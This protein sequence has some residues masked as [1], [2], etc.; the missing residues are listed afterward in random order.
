M[1][2]KIKA[3]EVVMS[4][5][6]RASW[7]L[8]LGSFILFL[9]LGGCAPKSPD[10]ASQAKTGA[11]G[12]SA[13]SGAAA[14]S[15]SASLN[16]DPQVVTEKYRTY[17]ISECNNLVTSTRTFVDALL[18]GDTAKGKRLYATTRMSYERIEPI[19]ES[20]GSLDPDI[21]GRQGDVPDADWRGFHRIERILWTGQEPAALPTYA[22]RLLEDVTLLRAKLDSVEITT[23]ALAL[24]AVDLLNEVATSKITGEEERYS[25]TDLYD[26]A[27]NVDGAREIFELLEPTVREKDAAL[28]AKTADGF[29]KVS[30]ALDR[31]RKGSDYALYTSLSTS[32]TKGLAQAVDAL[33]DPL[34]KV[35]ALMGAVK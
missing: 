25:H 30:A 33:A 21:D 31:Y 1:R 22:K 14:T 29:Q 32:E 3:Q 13:M 24:G 5:A 15:G 35:A 7:A 19:A 20:L 4:V 6:V 17:A 18:A 28:A 11:P 26:F 8:I 16:S 27:A 12:S 23:P 10:Q 34:A 9:G 2:I